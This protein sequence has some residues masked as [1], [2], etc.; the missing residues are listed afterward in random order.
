MQI[1]D[2]RGEHPGRSIVV[3][4]HPG[5]VDEHLRAIS[6]LNDARANDMSVLID[7]AKTDWLDSEGFELCR[8]QDC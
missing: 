3:V 5:H 1:L 6:S 2:A 4:S 8:L 7:L